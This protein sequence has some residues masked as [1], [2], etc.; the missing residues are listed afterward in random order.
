MIYVLTYKWTWINLMHSLTD[1]N[2][3]SFNWFSI[4]LLILLNDYSEKQNIFHSESFL[5]KW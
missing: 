3:K 4:S 5:I 2:I 1:S